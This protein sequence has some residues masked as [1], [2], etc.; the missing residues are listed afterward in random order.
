MK[1]ILIIIDNRLQYEKLKLIIEQHNRNDIDF[2][3]RHSGVYTDI[4]EHADFKDQNKI[5]DVK[6]KTS[7]IIESFELVISVHCYQFFPAE[8]VNNIRCINI[9]PGYNPIN[10]GWYPQV[11]AIINDLPIGATI[12]EMDAKLDNG[13]IIARVFVKKYPWDTS[14]SL[15]NRVLQAELDLFEQNYDRIFDSTYKPT[16]PEK[17]GNFFSKKN[18]KEL[19]EIDLDEKVSFRE[20]INRLRALTHGNYKNAYYTDPD[21]K[22]KV[23]LKL[24]LFPENEV[25]NSDK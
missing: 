13:P 14:Y 22:S 7:W 23:F 2:E 1:R 12:H 16:V 11:F 20:S 4:W 5:I 9:H 18:F 25:N 10:R 19:C 3:F 15:Y 17:E 24:E 21:S 8:L 6:E